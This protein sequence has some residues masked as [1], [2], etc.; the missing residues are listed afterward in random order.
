ML[1][2]RL[3]TKPD[4]NLCPR[5]GPL[6]VLPWPWT[7]ILNV[8]RGTQHL[9]R[10]ADGI[11]CRRAV[12]C[13]AT[14]STS[15]AYALLPFLLQSTCY[16]MMMMMMIMI[17]GRRTQVAHFPTK[18]SPHVTGSQCPLQSPCDSCKSVTASRLS[19]SGERMP[20]IKDGAISHR[21]WSRHLCSINV[22]RVQTRFKNL[23][24]FPIF[25]LE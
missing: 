20:R 8:P 21:A 9:I 10:P 23:F 16:C 6:L 24:L 17:M 25:T 12:S 11:L 7:L 2:A 18:A 5:L 13:L 1:A 15:H 14:L 19:T 22:D 3:T 4:N